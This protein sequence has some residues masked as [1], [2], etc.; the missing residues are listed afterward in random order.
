MNLVLAHDYLIQ[1]GGA[2]RVIAAMHGNFPAAPIFTSAVRH[3]GLWK[4]F[5]N[6]DI[7]TSWMQRLPFI[8]HPSHT[9]QVAQQVAQFVKPDRRR[10]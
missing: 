2:E 10:Q 5:Q 6:A 7:R 1:M 9:G 8:Q 4:E 3:S